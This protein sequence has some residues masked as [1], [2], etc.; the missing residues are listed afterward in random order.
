MHHHMGIQVAAGTGIDLLDRHAG[1]GDPAGI[2]VGLLIP[3]DHRA[4]ILPDR[5]RR[6][7]SNRVV[8]PEPGEET[9]FSTRIPFS[10]N[11]A[12]LKEAS[13]LFLDRISSSML[14]FL[15]RWASSWLC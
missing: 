3:F 1:G 8:L 4:T 10:L 14:I 13:R 15:L 12:R 11:R 6:V 5:S 7:R 2:V 9:R